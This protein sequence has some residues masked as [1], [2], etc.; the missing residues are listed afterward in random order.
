MTRSLG[1][2]LLRYIP[3]LRFRCPLNADI[4]GM[5]IEGA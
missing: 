3:E 5:A 1:Q 2:H 4:F